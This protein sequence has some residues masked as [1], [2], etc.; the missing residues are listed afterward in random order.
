MSTVPKKRTWKVGWNTSQDN[1]DWKRKALTFSNKIKVLGHFI[2]FQ[3]SNHTSKCNNNA[4]H[5]RAQRSLLT[6]ET[7][8]PKKRRHQIVRLTVERWLWLI[9]QCSWHRLVIHTYQNNILFYN[10]SKIILLLIYKLLR[11]NETITCLAVYLPICIRLGQLLTIYIWASFTVHVFLIP[12]STN[13]MLL[14]VAHG[15]VCGKR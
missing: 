3:M 2:L 1:D 9:E 4:T 8:K 5:S 15:L 14:G 13:A 12:T 11:C 6:F 7:W 10:I